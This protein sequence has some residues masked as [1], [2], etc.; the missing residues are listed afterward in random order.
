MAHDKQYKEPTVILGK[1]DYPK[2][3]DVFYNRYTERTEIADKDMD[4]RF[5]VLEEGL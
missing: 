3:G 4:E 5:L 1:L 2:T